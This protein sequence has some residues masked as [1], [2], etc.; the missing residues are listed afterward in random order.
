MDFFAFLWLTSLTVLL[1]LA[2][3]RYSMEMKRRRWELEARATEDDLTLGELRRLIREEI[4]AEL[5]AERSDQPDRSRAAER[6]LDEW[7][8]E[9]DDRYADASVRR[10]VSQR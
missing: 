5:D 7:E 4:R 3:M 9:A 1:P 10:R 2:G 8:D 6:W